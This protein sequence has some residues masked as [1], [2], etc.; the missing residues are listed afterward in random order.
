M[1]NLTLQNRLSVLSI[2]ALFALAVFLVV[3]AQPAGAVSVQMQSSSDYSDTLDTGVV[4]QIE[5]V[6][7][8]SARHVFDEDYWIANMHSI[9]SF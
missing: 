1:K 4:A 8:I 7:S 2:V 9:Q 5:N 3:D 6:F